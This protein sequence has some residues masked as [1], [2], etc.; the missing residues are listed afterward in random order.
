VYALQIIPVIGEVRG[1][2]TGAYWGGGGGSSGGD[3]R[4]R[5]VLVYVML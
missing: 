1:E 3:G 2:V 5:L 4:R